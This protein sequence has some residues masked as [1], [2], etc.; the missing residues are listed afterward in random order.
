MGSLGDI[1]I[2]NKHQS[3]RF[4]NTTLMKNFK[5]KN[6]VITGAGSGI[7]RALALEFSE[8]GSNLILNDFN[9]ISLQETEQLVKANGVNV[10]TESFDVGDA[11]RMFEF[12]NNAVKN[13]G[14]PDIIINNAGVALNAG[15]LND[16]EL[17]D[18]EWLFNINFWGVVNGTK[19]FLPL[20]SKRPEAAIVNISSVF[21]L[22]GSLHSTAYCASKF[23]VRGFT[24]TLLLELMDTNIQVHTVHPGGIKT[25]IARAALERN[26][27]KSDGTELEFE[28]KFLKHSPQ[29]AA[30]IIIKGIR[31]NK[32]RILIGSEAYAIEIFSRLLP[33]R[34]MKLVNK[35]FI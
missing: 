2:R 31:R 34:F 6:V 26:P 20:L 33:I 7:G 5:N 1:F 4:I 23:A 17:K 8:L 15:T 19:A 12:A 30:Q 3:N 13:L 29:K 21:G 11:S 28:K 9:T 35:Y 22:M 24:E 27:E 32:V 18:F 14:Q 10:Y 16:T 25:N